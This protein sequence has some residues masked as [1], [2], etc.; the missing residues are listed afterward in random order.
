M[1]EADDEKIANTAKWFLARLNQ[2]RAL[3]RQTA[4]ARRSTSLTLQPI[5]SEIARL[6]AKWVV[7]MSFVCLHTLSGCRIIKHQIVRQI[8]VHQLRSFS[9]QTRLS[10]HNRSHRIGRCVRGF[11][12]SWRMG[13]WFEPFG[14]FSII[15]VSSFSDD[16]FPVRPSPRK[17]CTASTQNQTE[18]VSLLSVRLSAVNQKLNF[19]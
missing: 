12:G 14:W 9:N 1:Q 11:S 19:Y 16:A 2:T 10:L 18:P 17:L 4:S 15:V 5:E 13:D 3:S 6:K 8:S 7:Q